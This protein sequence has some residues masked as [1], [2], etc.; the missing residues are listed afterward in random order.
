VDLG[1]ALITTFRRLYGE[2]FALD[3]VRHLLRHDASLSA[4]AQGRT[5]AEIRQLWNA[6]LEEFSRRRAA[7]LLYR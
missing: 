1:L 7:Y 2:S 5:P 6:D 4:L 3:K